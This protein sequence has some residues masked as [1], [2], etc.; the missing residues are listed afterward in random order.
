MSIRFL[1]EQ[2]TEAKSKVRFLDEAPASTGKVRFLDEAKPAPEVAAP[3]PFRDGS[4]PVAVVGVPSVAPAPRP[5]PAQPAAAASPAPSVPRFMRPILTAGMAGERGRQQ[6]EQEKAQR[7]QAAAQARTAELQQFQ[8]DRARDKEIDSQAKRIYDEALARAQR[9]AA[10]GG[11]M[12]VSPYLPDENEILQQ[13]K[14]RHGYVPGR[15]I[16]QAAAET[17]QIQDRLG[18][19]AAKVAQADPDLSKEADPLAAYRS[20]PLDSPIRRRVGEQAQRQLFGD[21]PY[22]PSLEPLDRGLIEEGVVGL[23]RGAA[24]LWN[25][26]VG[27][28]QRAFLSLTQDEELARRSVEDLERTQGGRIDVSNLRP[29]DAAQQMGSLASAVSA[30][31]EMTPLLAAQVTLF[32]ATG[33]KPWAF[34]GPSA[35]QVGTS[36]FNEAYDALT[37]MGADPQSATLGAMIEGTVNAAMDAVTNRLAFGGGALPDAIEAALKNQARGRMAQWLGRVA[38]GASAESMQEFTQQLS[39]ELTGA[40]REALSGDQVRGIEDILGRSAFAGAVAAIPG[41]AL[42]GNVML[43]NMDQTYG[44]GFGRDFVDAVKPPESD[45]NQEAPSEPEPRPAPAQPEPA[46]GT[47]PRIVPANQQMTGL[48]PNLRPREQAAPVQE[49]QPD[50]QAQPAQPPVETP[51]PTAPAVD[52]DQAGR[53]LGARL[54]ET[55]MTPEELEQTLNDRLDPLTPEEQADEDRRMAEIELGDR[56]RAGLMDADELGNVIADRLG[57]TPAPAEGNAPAQTAPPKTP[58]K[59]RQAPKPT[60]ESQTNAKAQVQE[61]GPVPDV[62]E[63]PTQRPAEG[64]APG[65]TP[66]REGQDRGASEVRAEGVKPPAEPPTKIEV[67][68]G[69]P[70]PPGAFSA[71]RVDVDAS[72]EALGLSNIPSPQTRSWESALEE[73][74]TK[75]DAEATD[76]L[77]RDTLLTPK[78]LNDTQTAALV[79]RRVEIGNDYERVL[80][81]I[82]AKQAKGEPIT[83]LQGELRALEDQFD[84]IT[85][86]MRTSGT[87][88]GRAL[89][90]QKLTINK[91]FDLVSLVQRYEANKGGKITNAERAQLQIL[92]DKLKT[93]EAELAAMQSRVTELEAVKTMNRQARTTRKAPTRRGE[94]VDK[95]KEL[96]TKGCAK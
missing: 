24:A 78:A 59:S 86:A 46:E 65:R 33:G 25:E 28:G 56:L 70:S 3:E 21:R 26:T 80:N 1:D 22:D 75:Y 8:Q 84:L 82:T 74:A 47:T 16:P 37:R 13:M 72:R 48:P 36:S 83:F 9:G 40:A 88:K 32:R 53:E 2:Q 66:Q 20:L 95:I 57:E 69:K 91:N 55:V 17:R 90:A 42:A 58:R 5:A 63:Q 18:L 7:T 67:E 19:V 6:V 30:I 64:Q 94:L 31:G 38:R 71:R 96:V 77:A 43:S 76:R 34:M 29:S 62:Q 51:E 49:T 50:A 61:A 15:S 93:V 89:A 92:S 85:K 14:R 4:D 12:D 35:L 27:A 23:G 87:E 10:Q 52:R 45:P 73:A 60:A 79:I 39:Q 68:K 54:R 44:E 41:G 81:E 11:V